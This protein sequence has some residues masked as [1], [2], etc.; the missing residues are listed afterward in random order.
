MSFNIWGGGAN[1]DK[2]VDDT[3]AAIQAVD[4]DIVGIQETQLEGPDCTAKHC[5]PA[6][7]TASRRRS[8]TRWATTTTSRPR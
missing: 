8:P 7:A 4:P 5:P 2:P 1:E 3:V 6:R